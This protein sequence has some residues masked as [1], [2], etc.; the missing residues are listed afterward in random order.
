MLAV[1]PAIPDTIPDVPTV[2]TALLLLLHVPPDVTLLNPV[3]LPVQ[4]NK[5]PVMEDG[6]SVTVTVVDTWQPVLIV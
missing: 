6:N 2:A 4:V 3:V 5:V 1:P